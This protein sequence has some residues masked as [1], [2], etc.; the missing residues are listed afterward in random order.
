MHLVNS[1]YPLCLFR[2]TWYI[3][4]ICS[5]SNLSAIRLLWNC[6]RYKPF[7][8]VILFY[9]LSSVKLPIFICLTS[10]L[11]TTFVR[12]LPFCFCKFSTILS[13]FGADENRWHQPRNFGRLCVIF[14]DASFCVHR[15]VGPGQVCLHDPAQYDHFS[16]MVIAKIK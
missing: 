10:L 12:S 8:V 6:T 9:P 13:I 14:A 4:F 3:F 5:A 11:H 16:I 15:S 7:G 1:I 2:C